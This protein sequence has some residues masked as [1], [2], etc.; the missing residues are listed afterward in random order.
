MLLALVYINS[1][2]HFQNEKNGL[3]LNIF[4]LCIFFFGSARSRNLAILMS[5]TF[6]WENRNS[7]FR[8]VND[9]S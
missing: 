3:I 1:N 9:L 2:G 8:I 7:Y 5:S 6:L 4:V